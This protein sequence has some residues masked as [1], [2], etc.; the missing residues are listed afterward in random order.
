[1]PSETIRCQLSGMASA[2]RQALALV[3][4]GVAEVSLYVFASRM[5]RCVSFTVICH[6]SQGIG[7]R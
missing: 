4:P 3:A 2:L 5:G 7:T 6:A 1:M